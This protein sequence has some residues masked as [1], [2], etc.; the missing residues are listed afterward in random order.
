MLFRSVELRPSSIAHTAVD[1]HLNAIF[2]IAFPLLLIAVHQMTMMETDCGTGSL[3]AADPK[4]MP[5]NTI[6]VGSL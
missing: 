5:S 2:G 4:S 6:E 3:A 1:L